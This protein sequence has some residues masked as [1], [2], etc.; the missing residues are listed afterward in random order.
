LEHFYVVLAALVFKISCRKIDTYR[1][2][3]VKKPTSVTSMGIGNEDTQ[4]GTCTLA[5]VIGL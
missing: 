5:S 2:T 3:E 4:R 1:E